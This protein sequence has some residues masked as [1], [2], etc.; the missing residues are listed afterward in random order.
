VITLI[1]LWGSLNE[2][3]KE[4]EIYKIELEQ[5]VN[6]VEEPKIL[7]SSDSNKELIEKAARERLGFVYPN[8]QVLVDISGN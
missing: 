7:L 4:L 8:E 3:Q 6:D 1:N 2:K 5:H